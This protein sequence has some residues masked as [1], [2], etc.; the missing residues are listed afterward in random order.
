MSEESFL[1]EYKKTCSVFGLTVHEEFAL[2]IYRS[3]K[4]TWKD[5]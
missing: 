5:A 1:D 4:L 2:Q 3:W